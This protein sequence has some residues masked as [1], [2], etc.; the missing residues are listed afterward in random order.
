MNSLLSS[1]NKM[2]FT[3]Y[4]KREFPDYSFV[5]EVYKRQPYNKIMQVVSEAFEVEDIT[6]LNYDVSFNYILKSD[7]DYLLQLSMLG[8]LFVLFVF[9]YNREIIP[10][11][12][13]I[14]SAPV[15][16]L[17]DNL[18]EYGFVKLDESILKK[19]TDFQ[20]DS[21]GKLSFY[22]ALFTNN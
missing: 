22:Q 9:D 14:E 4:K 19:S 7:E 15:K 1:I 11:E 20:N 21:G 17:L 13:L 16:F 8:K 12:G 3:A 6:E 18:K 5:Q 10:V 2:L